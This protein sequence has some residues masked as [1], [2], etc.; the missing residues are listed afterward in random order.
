[1]MAQAGENQEMGAV[2]LHF[3]GRLSQVLVFFWGGSGKG[4]HRDIGSGG[5][6]NAASGQVTLDT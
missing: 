1:M 2:I 5:H 4:K 6:A 3:F